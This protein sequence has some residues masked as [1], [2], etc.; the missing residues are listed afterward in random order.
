VSVL[1]FAVTVTT[2]TT[3]AHAAPSKAELTKQIDKTSDELGVIVESYNKLKEELKQTK[4][5]EGKLGE[6]MKPVREQLDTVSNEVG[7][8]ANQAYRRGGAGADASSLLS[9]EDGFLDRLSM[10]DYISRKRQ[11]QVQ[12]FAD[13]N[14]KF[15][16]QETELRNT[17]ERQEKQIAEMDARKVKIEGDVK[18]LLD[19]RKQVYGTSAEADP[20]KYTG[21]IPE[22]SGAAGKAVTFAYNQIG[23]PYG[24]GDEGP[25]SYDCSGLTM[26]AWA[27]A[28]KSLPHNA[29]M[30]HSKVAR[31]SRDQLQ[32]GDLVFYRSDQ[33]VGIYVGN[34]KIIDAPRTG[35]RVQERSIDISKPNG[36]G[37]VR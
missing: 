18:K 31:I 17:R 2:L 32:P 3:A 13:T 14:E 5:A 22:V 21:P 8:L 7:A 24:W 1:T 10:L 29:A 28:G 25:G 9:G 11:K 6:Q 4:D 35:T 34:N 30:Q 26:A 16:V 20:G 12:A 15:T 19:L 36:Y 27:A 23:K 33:H 37:R